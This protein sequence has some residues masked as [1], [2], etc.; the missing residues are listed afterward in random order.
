MHHLAIGQK[1]AGKTPFLLNLAL[2]DAHAAG[3]FSL[4]DPHGNLA[5]ALHQTLAASHHYFDLADPDCRLGCNPLALVHRSI[6]PLL[7][8]GLIETLKKQWADSWGARMEH[9]LRYA[10]LALLDQPQAD[11]RDIVRLYVDKDSAKGGGRD[12]R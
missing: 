8:S 11:I 4:I 1:G 2:H 6:R 5:R 12:H 10:I 9:M 3:G 7:A